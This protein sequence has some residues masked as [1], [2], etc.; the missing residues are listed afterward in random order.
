MK[1]LRTVQSTSGKIIRNPNRLKGHEYIFDLNNDYKSNT[2]KILE[3]PKNDRKL[4]LV[5][6]MN[7]SDFLAKRTQKLLEKYKPDSVL[8]QTTPDWYD[9]LNNKS[10]TIETNRDIMDLTGHKLLEHLWAP[11]NIRGRIFIARFYSWAL[12]VRAFL[13]VHFEEESPFL[14]SLEVYNTVKYARENDKKIFYADKFLGLK[15]L[16]GLKIEKRLSFVDVLCRKY[17]FNNRVSFWSQQFDSMMN[18]MALIGLDNFSESAD[19]YDMN[20]L[21]SYLERV[22]PH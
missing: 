19:Y 13:N 17:I 6:T 4:I 20:F 16:N 14:P 7:C 11:Q 8:V 21:N 9:K 5:G 22:M 3:D 18:N 12:I 15:S 1:L 10:K 2:V